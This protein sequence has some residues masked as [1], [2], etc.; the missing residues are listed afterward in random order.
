[1]CVCVCASDS[2]LGSTGGQ[3]E[4]HDTRH[5]VPGMDARH[6]VQSK[7]A[8]TTTNTTTKQQHTHTHIIMSHLLCI[9]TCLWGCSALHTQ[10]LNTHT[11]HTHY[12]CARMERLLRLLFARSPWAN[13]ASTLRTLWHCVRLVQ[14][15]FCEP[16]RGSQTFNSVLCIFSKQTRRT[17]LK[18]ITR[19][20]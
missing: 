20:L 4:S 5:G 17:S 13:A 11:W 2:C 6:D 15:V 3:H 8:D 9:N 18:L 10:L 1:M 19:K 7:A 16:D 12:I 14:Y